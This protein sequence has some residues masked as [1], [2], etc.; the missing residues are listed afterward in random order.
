MSTGNIMREWAASEG[1]TIYEFEDKV[2]KHDPA[3]D[4]KL[5]AK[6]TQY[7]EENTDFIFES[8]LAWHFIPDSMK[9]FLDCDTAERYRRIHQREGEDLTEITEKNSKREAE[10]ALR[11]SQVYPDISFPPKAETFDI[12]IDS[13]KFLPEE[14]VAQILDKIQ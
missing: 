3:F 13:E 9:I 4:N 11:Y 8:R 14:I 7:G 6:S 12:V 2:V 5:D 1:M 10:L